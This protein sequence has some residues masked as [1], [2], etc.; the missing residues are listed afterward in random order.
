MVS[1]NTPDKII[2]FVDKDF[3]S[4]DENTMVA[5]A[6]RIMYERDVCSMIVTR[7]DSVRLLRQ[8]VRMITAR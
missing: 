6:A 1:S 3:V 7:N 8:L 5:E 2:D 4:L